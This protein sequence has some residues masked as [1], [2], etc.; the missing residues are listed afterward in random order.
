MF[1]EDPLTNSIAIINSAPVLEEGTTFVFGSWICVANGS[2]SFNNHL[3]DTRK[4][5]KLDNFIDNLDEMLLPNLVR[6][7]RLII[8]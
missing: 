7:S 4:L 6:N 1:I 3:A 8:F 5:Q 2:D